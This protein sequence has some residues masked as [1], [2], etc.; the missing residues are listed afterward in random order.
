MSLKYLFP[1]PEFLAP[2]PGG[3]WADLPERAVA[4]RRPLSSEIFQ[5]NGTLSALLNPE[6]SISSTYPKTHIHI[7]A[8]VFGQKSRILQRRP[9][10]QKVPK[11]FSSNKTGLTSKVVS[12]PTTQAFQV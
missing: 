11:V 8:T 4:H 5:Y 7:Q 10:T 2:P 12:P 3:L 1:P 9:C 6:Q